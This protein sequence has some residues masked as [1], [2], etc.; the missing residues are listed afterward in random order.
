MSTVKRKRKPRPAPRYAA[1]DR[2]RVK[3]GIRDTDY[4]DMPLG[5]WAGSIAEVEKDGLCMVRW[6]KKT[7][8]AI[9]PVFRN[10]CETDGLELEHY[11]LPQDDLEPDQGDPLEIECP[12]EITTEPPSSK[13]QDDRIRMVFGLTSNDPLPDVDDE[14]LE[15]YHN[16]LLTNL[17][18]PFGAEHTPESG[19]LFRHSYRIKAIG[20]GDPDEPMIDEMYG[21]LC[22]ARHRRRAITMPLGE[23]EVDKGKPNRQLV[24]DY[25]QWFWNNR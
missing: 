21:I 10:R 18:F 11:W 4:P 2:V 24:K 3:R 5:G 7:L 17:L 14:T 16:Y 9:H 22:E 12:E 23:L 6:S 20:L 15:T 1:R 19:H 25:C 8:D 13:D